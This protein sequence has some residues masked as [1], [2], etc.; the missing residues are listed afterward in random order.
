LDG[1]SIEENKEGG[2]QYK[3]QEISKDEVNLSEQDKYENKD[4]P[5]K[6][7]SQDPIYENLY[8]LGCAGNILS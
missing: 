3:A 1:S 7:P 2:A 6:E 4:Y 5:S 8:T